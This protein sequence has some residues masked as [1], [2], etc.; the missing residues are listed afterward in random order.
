MKVFDAEGAEQAIVVLNLETP[1]ADSW[2]GDAGSSVIK[3][4]VAV[5]EVVG[6]VDFS[7]VV[8]GIAHSW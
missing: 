3:F 5:S 2:L 1:A 8:D 4:I 7:Q 6:F